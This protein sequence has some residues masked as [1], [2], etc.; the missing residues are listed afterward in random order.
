RRSF[1]LASKESI[2]P[3]FTRPICMV[4]IALTVLTVVARNPHFKGMMSETRETVS[5]SLGLGRK[6]KES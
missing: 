3:L 1:M 4:L 5:R 2:A 6:K